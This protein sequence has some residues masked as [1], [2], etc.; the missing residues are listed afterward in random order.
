MKNFKH[1]WSLRR[2]LFEKKE[3]TVIFQKVLRIGPSSSIYKGSMLTIDNLSNLLLTVLVTQYYQAA[4]MFY[5]MTD[6]CR[7]HLRVHKNKTHPQ[8]L[9]KTGCSILPTTLP[10]NF[11]V[12][13]N[14]VNLKQSW[15][16]P[17]SAGSRPA[18]LLCLVWVQAFLLPGWEAA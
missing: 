7:T 16:P 9:C 10:G 3:L 2:C 1:K 15:S 13:C 12:L 8:L 14:Y 4:L 6:T 17:S 18:V 11:S 5:T